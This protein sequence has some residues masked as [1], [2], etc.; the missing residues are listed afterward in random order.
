MY[1][2]IKHSKFTSWLVFVLMLVI[3]QVLAW[4]WFDRERSL[5]KQLVERE[6]THI[7]NLIETTIQNSNSITSVMASM[8]EHDLLNNHFDLIAEKLLNHNKNIDGIQL[9]QDMVITHT[10]PLKGNEQAIGYNLKTD[11]SHVRELML[12]SSLQQLHFEGPFNLRQG[13]IGFVGRY[14]ILQQDTLWGFAAVIIRKENFIK[15]LGL[16]QSGSSN[17]FYYQLRK[18]QEGAKYT[19]L[20]DDN[21]TDF[22]TGVIAEKYN[23]VGDWIIQVKLKK[24]RAIKM[25]WSLF[26]IGLLISFIMFYTMVLN[27][28]RH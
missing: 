4:K 2:I 19:P 7:G 21:R 1:A 9:V 8:V 26:L 24:S 20:F 17:L 15:A 28:K 6:V 18:Q 22:S 3:T 12:S 16:N 23:A 11:P 5:E 25:G 13:G 10:Y 27:L 14:P